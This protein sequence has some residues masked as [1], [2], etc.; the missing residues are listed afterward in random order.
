MSL[1]Q[2]GLDIPE[3]ITLGDHSTGAIFH[4]SPSEGLPY[5]YRYALWRD[6]DS[7]GVKPPLV[8]IGLNPSTATELLD[9]P[10]IRRCRG[11]SRSYGLQGLVMLNLYGFRSTDP[12]PLWG[13]QDPIGKWNDFI[14]SNVCQSAS[15][16]GGKVIAAWGAFP[17]ATE[18]AKDVHLALEQAM[19]PL[20][21]F[22]LTKGGHPKHPLY[23]SKDTVP[24]PLHGV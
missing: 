7:D 10:T 15:A 24:V 9:D 14:I 11:F 21:T 23:L 6:L 16:R 8:V 12:S 13:I 3:L 17:R 5:E 22:G 1:F 18:R 2:V 20:L 19:V 4:D